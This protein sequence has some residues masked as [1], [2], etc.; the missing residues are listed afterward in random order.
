MTTED[1]LGLMATIVTGGAIK[2][3]KK[4]IDRGMD[5]VASIPLK[6]YNKY[7]GDKIDELYNEE[8]E[9]RKKYEYIQRLKNQ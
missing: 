1:K 7:L 2:P 4:I 6:L 5:N 8:L 3:I 9:I